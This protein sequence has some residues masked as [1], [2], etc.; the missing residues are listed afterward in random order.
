MIFCSTDRSRPTGMLGYRLDCSRGVCASGVK[1]WH[2]ANHIAIAF[3]WSSKMYKSASFHQYAKKT[4][5]SK[6]LII[7][8]ITFVY[9]QPTLTVSVCELCN[10]AKRYILQQKWI[11]S[12]PRNTI[13]QLSTLAPQTV[14]LLNR[15]HW[16]LLANKVKPNCKQAKITQISTCGIPIVGMLHYYPRQRRTIGSFLS[17]AAVLVLS[18]LQD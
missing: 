11:G 12:A 17:T 4:E 18:L 14:H 6:L 9:C 3:Y 10:V 16:C 1:R 8:A 15:R 2:L 13:L 7:I 5:K